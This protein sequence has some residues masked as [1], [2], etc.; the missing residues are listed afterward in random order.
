MARFY[1]RQ[2]GTD[3]E[4]DKATQGTISPQNYFGTSNFQMIQMIQREI[5]NRRN[6]NPFNKNPIS[7]RNYLQTMPM[8]PK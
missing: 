6:S 3:E 1:G 7:N 2:N 8:L 4:E 5:R